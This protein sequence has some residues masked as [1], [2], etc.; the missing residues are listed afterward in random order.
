[1]QDND[2]EDWYDAEGNYAE[3]GCYDAGGHYDSERGSA[4]ADDYHD[5]MKDVEMD[6]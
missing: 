3:N 6:V 5:R 1:M 2:N 4:A